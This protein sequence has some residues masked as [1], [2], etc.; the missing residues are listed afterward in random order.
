MFLGLWLRRIRSIQEVSCSLC[1]KVVGGSESWRPATTGRVDILVTL[2]SQN[3]GKKYAYVVHSDEQSFRLISI[4][5]SLDWLLPRLSYNNHHRN[6][7][8]ISQ[9]KSLRCPKFRGF[10]PRQNV[11]NDRGLSHLPNLQLPPPQRAKSKSLAPLAPRPLE[12]KRKKESVAGI[13][14]WMIWILDW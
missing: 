12:I 9:V 1:C 6:G 10:H 2:Q 13:S 7:C 5:V 3:V 11:F 4:P 14:W 8:I